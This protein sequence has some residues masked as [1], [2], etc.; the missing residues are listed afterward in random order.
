M[1]GPKPILN[2]TQSHSFF[3]NF[4]VGSESVDLGLNAKVEFGCS[5]VVIVRSQES[6]QKLPAFLQYALCLTIYECKGLEFNDVIL[7]NFFTESP[8]KWNILHSLDAE[9]HSVSGGAKLNSNYI[10]QYSE[11]CSDLKLLY[12]AITR[13]KKTLVIYDD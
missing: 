12:T 11:L 8:A 1:Q 2:S 3:L 5:Q 10:N 4:L 9:A 13:P 7:F 6:K